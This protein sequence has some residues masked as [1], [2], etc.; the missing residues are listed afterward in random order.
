MKTIDKLQLL[1]NLQSQVES[2][3]NKAIAEYQNMA[4]NLLNRPSNTGGW[5]IAQ[6]LEHLNSY[7][8]YY[9]PLIKSGVETY[10]GKSASS[11]TGSWLGNYFVKMMDPTSG[12]KK[13]KAFKGH[14]PET[15]LDGAAV[16]AKFID[17]QEQLLEYLKRAEKVDLN[18]IKI[19]ISIS[20]FIR[21]NLGDTFRFIVAHDERHMLQAGR[22]VTILHEPTAV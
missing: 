18:A 5:S 17:Q 7:G 6:C 3:L 11:F 8:D 19:P 12:N 9:L 2:H 22:N 15:K 10:S 21:L 13:Y 20:R 16:V 1:H 4:D 14:I